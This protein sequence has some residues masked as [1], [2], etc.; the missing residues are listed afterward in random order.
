[1][2]FLRESY[3]RS[4]AENN[5]SSRPIELRKTKRREVR[6]SSATGGEAPVLIRI[7]SMSMI[8]TEIGLDCDKKHERQLGHGEPVRWR[9]RARVEPSVWASTYRASPAEMRFGLAPG[10]V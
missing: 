10:A 4:K 7:R 8:M 2:Y 9:T 1:M 5:A 3:L 6:K